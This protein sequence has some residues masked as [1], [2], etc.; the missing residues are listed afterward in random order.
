MSDGVLARCL[1]V[2][3]AAKR[4]E[5]VHDKV[6]GTTKPVNLYR[7]LQRQGYYWPDMARDAK[8]REEACLKCTWMPD[9]AECAFINVMKRWRSCTN[10]M[11]AP[12]RSTKEGCGCGRGLLFAIE[13]LDLILAYSSSPMRNIFSYLLGKGLRHKAPPTNLLTSEPI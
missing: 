5:E 12:W 3:E 4:L 13:A 2:E 7:R 6:C 8:A 11:L 9:R 1:G 10:H